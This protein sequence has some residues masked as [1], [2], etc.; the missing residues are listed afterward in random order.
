MQIN[1]NHTWQFLEQ[2]RTLMPAMLSLGSL[3]MY[4]TEAIIYSKHQLQ[5]WE[6]H[7]LVCGTS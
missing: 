5:E 7:V 6:L 1:N 3:Q 2:S 4:E